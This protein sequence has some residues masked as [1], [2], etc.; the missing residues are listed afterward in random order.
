MANTPAK[1]KKALS[2]GKRMPSGQDPLLRKGMLLAKPLNGNKKSNR[3]MRQHKAKKEKT[4]K[5]A[6]EAV[7]VSQGGEN[8]IGNIES[9]EKRRAGAGT[10][11]QRTEEEKT[12][13]RFAIAKLVA[14][15]K[16]VAQI[17]A[18][19]GLSESTVRADLHGM[20]PFFKQQAS[21]DVARVRGEHVV[22][23]R[24]LLDEAMAGLEASKA[25]QKKRTIEA[26]RIPETKN[27]HGNVRQAVTGRTG[28]VVDVSIDRT[29][30]VN[31]INASNAL[32]AREAKLLGLD[33][34]IDVTLAMTIVE[35]GRRATLQAVTKVVKDPALIRL[36]AAE[37]EG[38]NEESALTEETD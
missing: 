2:K 18:I 38:G 36:I 31:Y 22:L 3:R 21:L 13:D 15:R 11:S 25:P 34:P 16:T 27:E 12:R 35:Q 9:I 29:A 20:D 23:I 37:L 26:F 10:R 4:L 33:A 30:N 7:D 32:L 8:T 24:T 28:K 14:L 19:T 6:V 5:A 17:A 1:Q